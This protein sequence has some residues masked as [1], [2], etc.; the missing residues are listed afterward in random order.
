MATLRMSLS[1]SARF[2]C[3]QPSVG[4][5]DRYDFSR[6][7]EVWEGHDSQKLLGGAALPALRW[8]CLLSLRALA[9]EV[10]RSPTTPF[11][12]HRQNPILSSLTNSISP[13]KSW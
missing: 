12:L 7:V 8:V 2:G 4:S 6:A 5:W 3:L 11:K 10:R 9:P 1:L 13:H